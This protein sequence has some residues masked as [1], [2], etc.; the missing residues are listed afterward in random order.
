M[1]QIENKPYIEINNKQQILTETMLWG[2]LTVVVAMG[3]FVA[4]FCFAG[5]G[6]GQK[7]IF[8]TGDL[9]LQY[10]GTNR[11]FWRNLLQ[12]NSLVYSFSMGMGMP[13]ISIEAFECFSLFHILFALIED[14][15]LAAFLIIMLKIGCCAGL[16]FLYAKKNLRAENH[17]AAVFGIYYAMCGFV[18]GSICQIAFLDAV[19]LL[20]LFAL[21]LKRSIR[22]G[23]YLGLS[24]LY[25]CS[26][27]MMF[28]TGYMLGMFTAILYLTYLLLERD[29]PGEDKKRHIIRYIFATGI[30]GMLSAVVTVPTALYIFQNRA[31]DSTKWH[32]LRFSILDLVANLYM[33]QFQGY[34]Q[35]VP[36]IY[37]GLGTLLVLATA[38]ISKRKYDK[39][40][41]V[42]A[43]PAFFLLLCI[44]VKPFY[45]LI[46]AF[47]MPDTFSYRFLYMF[48]FW[49]LSV[50]VVAIRREQAKGK[51]LLVTIVL[52]AF[53][54][55]IL[56]MAQYLHTEYAEGMS[57]KAA[58]INLFFLLL[59][60][61][62][63][64]LRTPGKA[65]QIAMVLLAGG[66]IAINAW[67]MHT[68][69][70][71]EHFRVRDYYE[72][73]NREGIAAT[74]WITQGAEDAGK[75]R[76][77][78]ENVVFPNDSAY[79]GYRGLG[80]FIT[81]EQPALRKTL[82]DLGYA[83]SPRIV[84]DYGSTP[85]S[86][87]LFAQRYLVHGID[88]RY[89]SADDFTMRENMYV[90]PVAYTVSDN[91]RNYSAEADPFTNQDQ[92]L[93]LMRG[94]NKN[95]VYHAI[96]DGITWQEDGIALTETESGY[97]LGLLEGRENGT[98]EYAVAYSDDTM[99]YAYF[100][101]V[102]KG[103]WGHS[104]YLF[105]TQTDIGAVGWDPLL[106]FARIF[107]LGQNAAG[108]YVAT[109]NIDGSITREQDYHQAYFAAFDPESFVE[110][111]LELRQGAADVKEF[112]DG[113]LQCVVEATKE[114]K[115]LFTSIPYDTGWEAEV[116]GRPVA[117]ISVV[118]GAFLAVPLSEGMHKIELKYHLPGGRTGFSVSV[119]G[120][121][122][123]LMWGLWLQNNRRKVRN[124]NSSY[125]KKEY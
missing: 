52:S 123:I 20:P 50:A 10:V 5:M 80:Y 79:F 93:A 25:A 34:G 18:V 40:F 2:L 115:L 112:S 30:G 14:A 24:L 16:F 21:L 62:I 38:A 68:P 86:R 114:K 92:L 33:G 31:A 64:A 36:L 98:L 57:W 41:M 83:T 72:E 65:I 99:V 7:H 54:P 96:S 117:C 13:T 103:W 85:V 91:I 77:Y 73:W 100:D 120:I 29:L 37:C 55:V 59:W 122:I 47:D 43:L 116:D 81:A 17:I 35:N 32:E 69:D 53:Y 111:Y 15:D 125:I 75:Y 78:Y 61:V 104:A 63:L 110:N 71:A 1:E 90:L 109:I 101:P 6:P 119:I 3:A 58:G 106:S 8:M 87:M 39:K 23:K 124:C 94:K 46:N 66:E 27:I 51:V 74:E 22:T 107:P 26:F 48:S 88:P 95:P 28:Y 45:L 56:V 67:M 42:S 97:H 19:Y 4:A 49:V 11:M 89:E 9:Y 102:V 76:V 118:E 108:E 44:F 84:C 82:T 12:G 60:A 113:Y 121:G 70:S 105:S